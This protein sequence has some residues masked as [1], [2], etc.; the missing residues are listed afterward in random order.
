MTHDLKTFWLIFMREPN[1]T[2]YGNIYEHN[3]VADYQDYDHFVGYE[4]IEIDMGE[5]RK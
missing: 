2:I 1:G 3:A 5:L 4:K